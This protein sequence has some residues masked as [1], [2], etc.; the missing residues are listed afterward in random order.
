M[1]GE[2][3]LVS[4]GAGGAPANE[5]SD[6][7]SISADGTKVVF[8]SDASNIISG[9][10]NGNT[11]DVFMRDMTTG[12]TTLVDRT[13][14]GEQPEFP[15]GTPM[16]SADGRRVVFSALDPLDPVADTNA[17]FDIYIRDVEAGTTRLASRANGADGAV[18][19][20]QN[21]GNLDIDADGSRVVFLTT[22]GNL[23]DGDANVHLDVHMRDVDAG[24]TTWVSRPASGLPTE[25][26]GQGPAIS[27][28]GTVAA[29]ESDSP[30]I[31]PG[32][33]NA[34]RD[35]FVRDLTAD[36]TTLI[37]SG[38]GG[39]EGDD[40]SFNPILSGDGRRIGFDSDAENLAGTPNA[41]RDAFVRDVAAGP[42]RI[43]S[44]GASGAGETTAAISD[45]DSAG[46]C[47]LFTSA[48]RAFAPDVVGSAD[49]THV[50]LRALEKACPTP[51]PDP[52]PGPGPGPTP[53]PGADKTRP[54]ISALR[55]TNKRF[56]VAPG[57]TAL[58]AK[59]TKRG[60]VIRFKLSEK[61]TTTLRIER[62]RPGRR[63]G[64]KCVKPRR[65]L[66]RKCT[67]YVLTRTLKRKKTKKGSNSVRFSGR[68]GRKALGPGA[69]RVVAG[70]RDAAGNRA[71]TRS[72]RFTIVRR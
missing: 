59:A 46:N 4:I 64:K 6:L 48:T 2:F 61:A 25:G 54:V 35:V 50:Y 72:A 57:A 27:A 60:T 49:F 24:T 21:F 47:V 20:G 51:G 67:R 70:A 22:S 44:E 66:K 18:G 65:G 62:A 58:S 5:D 42:V 34:K 71:K 45:L 16:I 63:S 30:T 41:L 38:P 40:N 10:V 9:D 11:S 14:A 55:L 23:D 37:S 69:Y 56:R 36:T 28:D 39:E 13:V 68:L 53:Q 29:F 43:V 3:A 52:G 32:D 7:A 12:T 17:A 33:T 31:L 1:T 8:A 19:D 15:S 26:G